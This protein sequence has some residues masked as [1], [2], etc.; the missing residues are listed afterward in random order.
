MDAA[1]KAAF[2]M[3]P[4]VS[5]LRALNPS[6]NPCIYLLKLSATACKF[7]DSFIALPNSAKE[8]VTLSFKLSNVFPNPPCA[9]S[10]FAKAETER[11]INSSLLTP[12][13]LIPSAVTVPNSSFITLA[14]SGSLSFI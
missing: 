7:N 5:G 14:N 1:T 2:T 13:A 12:I 3:K 8:A 9:L 6:T 4:C 11:V 10:N